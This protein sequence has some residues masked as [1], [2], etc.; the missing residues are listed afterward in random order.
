MPV[1]LDRDSWAVPDGTF[2]AVLIDD[3]HTTPSGARWY[4]PAKLAVYVELFPDD[5][6]SVT[7]FRNLEAW[8]RGDQSHRVPREWDDTL[9]LMLALAPSQDLPAIFLRVHERF[10]HPG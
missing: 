5:A 7:A 4:D 6:V 9:A 2:K 3:A 1:L 8:F 10:R